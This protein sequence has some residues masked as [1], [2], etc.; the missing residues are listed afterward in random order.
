MVMDEDED[1]VA[2]SKN[3]LPFTVSVPTGMTVSVVVVKFPS[4]SSWLKAGN[5][6]I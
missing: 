4:I 3:K 2:S 6:T 5:S 1:M